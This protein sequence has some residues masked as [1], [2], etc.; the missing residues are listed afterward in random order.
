M[1]TLIARHQVK[2]LLT[3]EGYCNMRFLA[4]LPE[5]NI[6]CFGEYRLYRFGGSVPDR[7]GAASFETGTA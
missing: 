6:E 4:D 7:N 5:A 2:Y 1:G 3:Y